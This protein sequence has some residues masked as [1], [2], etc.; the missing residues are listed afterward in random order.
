VTKL[1][2]SSISVQLNEFEGLINELPPYLYLGQLH[3]I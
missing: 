3:L 1:K 2:D